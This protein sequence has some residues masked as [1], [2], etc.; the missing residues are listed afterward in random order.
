MEAIQSTTVGPMVEPLNVGHWGL[1]VYWFLQMKSL[2]SKP[3]FTSM[4]PKIVRAI[5]PLSFALINLGL[6]PL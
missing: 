4:F 3:L 2:Q 6:L 5:S 1:L